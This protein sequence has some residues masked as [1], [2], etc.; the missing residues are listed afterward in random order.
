MATALCCGC[1]RRHFRAD[2]STASRAAPGA[3]Q[4]CSTVVRGSASV[5]KRFWRVNRLLCKYCEAT[6]L[7]PGVDAYLCGGD[8][9]Y[10]KLHREWIRVCVPCHVRVQAALGEC[11]HES[12]AGNKQLLHGLI[13]QAKARPRGC[14]ASWTSCKRQRWSLQRQIAQ[15]CSAAPCDTAQR[16]IAPK[17][18]HSQ[19]ACA[20]AAQRWSRTPSTPHH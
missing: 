16:V 7:Q 8:D 5:L 11:P 14:P 1:A 15:Q 2:A 3:A 17:S 19:A 13:S 20:A 6:A 9:F 4:L 10:V 18:T 12:Y